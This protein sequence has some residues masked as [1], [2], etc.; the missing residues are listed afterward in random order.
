MVHTMKQLA[1]KRPRLSD[2]DTRKRLK[3]IEEKLRYLRD[4]E[5]AEWVDE[6]IGDRSSIKHGKI[7]GEALKALQERGLEPDTDAE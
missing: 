2:E 6:Y 5:D 1:S 7:I 4:E 3:T